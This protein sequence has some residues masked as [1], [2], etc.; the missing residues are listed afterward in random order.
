MGN[1]TSTGTVVLRGDTSSLTTGV[2]RSK[3]AL[4]AMDQVLRK[5][6]P[7]LGDMSKAAKAASMGTD[8]L[9]AGVLG[10]V[11][12]FGPWGMVIGVAA[13]AL[14]GYV[15]QT[16][17]A[18]KA[19][20]EFWYEVRNAGKQ[21]EDIAR[22]ADAR[23]VHEQRFI[24]R[25]MS[26]TR[27]EREEVR[28]MED[29]IA[30]AKGYGEAIDDL[31]IKL[32]RLRAAE[33]LAASRVRNENET[34]EQFEE[35]RGK[36]VSD[37]RRLEREAEL[38][39]IEADAAAGSRAATKIK[40][41]GKKKAAKPE[42]DHSTDWE[43]MRELEAARELAEEKKRLREQDEIDFQ[44]M[45][46][47]FDLIMEQRESAEQQRHDAA[48]TRMRERSSLAAIE[49]ADLREIEEQK[50]EQRFAFESQ[51]A[52]ADADAEFA[53]QSAHEAQ[54]ARIE[55][56]KRAREEQLAQIERIT[57]AGIGHA[58][59]AVAGI[60]SIADA[61]NNARRAAQAQGK[62]ETEVARAVKQAEL[63]AKAA[64]MQSIRDMMAMEALR[65]GGLALGALASTWGIPN[66]SSI[67]YF[68]AAAALGAGAVAAGARSNSLSD[69]AAGMDASGGG[70]PF[71]AA[72]GIGGSGGGG[73]GTNRGGSLPPG[74]GNAIPG[75]PIGQT[76]SPQQNN[77]GG[78]I[79]LNLTVQGHLVNDKQHI[80]YIAKRLE[81]RM[82]SRPRRTGT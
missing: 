27:L 1:A 34:D 29:Q 14:I 56:E 46:E 50:I 42:K 13:D 62:S 3:D 64:R 16:D 20:R 9:T 39:Q 74:S 70:S 22:K 23:E 81:E 55:E 45:N 60:I 57:Q 31:V 72:S 71:G 2:A 79:V 58:Q 65:F 38:A 36:L 35:R 7:A 33:L 12:G 48:L 43:F 61:R 53:R 73:R 49:D 28:A 6:G 47:R 52:L 67:L 66:P 17:A 54:M 18:T 30:A 76:S 32:D 68:A 15:A 82:H 37:A 21:M 78:G 51:L 11:K 40:V 8:L 63:Q 75:S 24:E 41:G 19:T 77:G 69:Q 44:T 10:V 59:T 80:D 5:N 26:M 4:Q 25:T